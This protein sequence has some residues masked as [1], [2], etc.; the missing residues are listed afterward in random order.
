[1]NFRVWTAIRRGALRLKDA[2]RPATTRCGSVCFRGVAP[3]GPPKKGAVGLARGQSL[4]GHPDGG[5][6]EDDIEDANSGQQNATRELW[7]THRG[8]Q[9]GVGDQ[10]QR[11]IHS[12]GYAAEE[13]GRK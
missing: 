12:H 9:P 1:M 8:Q 7:P 5:E 2:M 13:T 3:R 11:A 10:Q 6:R 4:E